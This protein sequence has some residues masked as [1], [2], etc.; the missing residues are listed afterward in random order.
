MLFG[1]PLP[2]DLTGASL[3]QHAAVK[4]FEMILSSAAKANPNTL[5]Q[6]ICVAHQQQANDIKL[7]KYLF[8]CLHAMFSHITVA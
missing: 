4:A 8:I 2:D 1:C 5:Y 7:V 3:G 6:A